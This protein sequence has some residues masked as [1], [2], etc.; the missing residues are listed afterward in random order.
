M[1]SLKE[2]YRIGNGP[3]SSHTIGPKN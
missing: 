3:S 2:L 1:E